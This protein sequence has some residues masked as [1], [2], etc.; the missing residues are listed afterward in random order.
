MATYWK[1]VENKCFQCNKQVG[2]ISIKSGKIC[3]D[4]LA[5]NWGGWHKVQGKSE[6]QVV[7]SSCQKIMAKAARKLQRQ[8]QKKQATPQN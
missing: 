4:S 3:V 1:N 2:K 8:Q 5:K 6:M 7:C